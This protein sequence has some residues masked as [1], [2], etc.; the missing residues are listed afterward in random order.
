MELER[1]NRT[2][3]LKKKAKAE[4]ETLQLKEELAIHI[5]ILKESGRDNKLNIP[6]KIMEEVFDLTGN[7]D[8]IK[9]KQIKT[10]DTNL[11]NLVKLL[12][13]LMFCISLITNATT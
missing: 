11:M 13:K 8:I 5:D 2:E 3:E 4:L 9:A 7:P 12:N 6:S 10:A 1:K